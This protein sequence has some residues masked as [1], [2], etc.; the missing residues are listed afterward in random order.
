[1]EQKEY[2][3]SEQ[4]YKNLQEINNALGIIETRGDSTMIMANIRQAMSNILQ[5][6]VEIP[7]ERNKKGE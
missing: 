4:A 7:K 5:Q 2:K 6:A 1:M 3:I